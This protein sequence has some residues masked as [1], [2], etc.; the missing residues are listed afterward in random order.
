MSSCL[1][2]VVSGRYRF[3]FCRVVRHREN[4]LH[5]SA[6]HGRDN[7]SVLVKN[8]SIG[9]VD[10]TGGALLNLICS[11]RSLQ[12]LTVRPTIAV[13]HQVRE[14]LFTTSLTGMDSRNS[15]ILPAFQEM[16]LITNEPPYPPLLLFTELRNLHV[17]MEAIQWPANLKWKSLT[18]LSLRGVIDIDDNL[19]AFMCRAIDIS[20]NCILQWCLC[21]DRLALH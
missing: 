18:D 3:L 4:S 16:R 8:L 2:K 7:L 14:R 11:D 1:S 6:I 17:D 15:L 9:R 12:Q 20:E 10:D 19:G 5:F 13:A 21:S